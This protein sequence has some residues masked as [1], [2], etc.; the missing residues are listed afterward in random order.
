[1]GGKET[2]SHGRTEASKITIEQLTSLPGRIRV[3]N[4]ER[5]RGT[6][7]HLYF[8]DTDGA[9]SNVYIHCELTDGRGRTNKKD[10]KKV[11]VKMMIYVRTS[12]IVHEFEM[13]A[14]ATTSA[15]LSEDAGTINLA[16][17]LADSAYC[18]HLQK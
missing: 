3:L 15:C 16:L 17:R 5:L 14:Y 4:G 13:D 10:L 18:K 1:M 9:P 11:M 7:P 8:D 2:R 12:A 6:S